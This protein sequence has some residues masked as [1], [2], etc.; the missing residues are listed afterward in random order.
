[1][2]AEGRIDISTVNANH[3][4]EASVSAVAEVSL[5]PVPAEVF[6]RFAGRWVALRDGAVVASARTLEELTA[7]E[8]V[9]DSDTLFRAPEPNS[10]FL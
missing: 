5:P 9:V 1:M 7:D 3:E 2:V 8:R 4:S 10:K 6:E